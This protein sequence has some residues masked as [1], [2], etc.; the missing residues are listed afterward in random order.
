MNLR[1]FLQTRKKGFDRNKVSN[2]KENSK[3]YPT[4]VNGTSKIK[5]SC[6]KPP[7]NSFKKTTTQ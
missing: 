1:F 7:K 2:K 6:S 3:K 5:K 4:G